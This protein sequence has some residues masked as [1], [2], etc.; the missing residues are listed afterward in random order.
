MFIVIWHILQIGKTFND[1]DGDFYSKRNPYKAKRRALDQ[2]RRLGYVV[3]LE[4]TAA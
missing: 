1:P 2:L 4:P 3:T